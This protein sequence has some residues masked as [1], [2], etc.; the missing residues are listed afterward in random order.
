MTYLDDP[1]FPKVAVTINNAHNLVIDNPYL[2][3]LL[4]NA[5]GEIIGG[6]YAYPDPIPANGSLNYEVFVTNVTAD[7]PARVEAYV[8]LT[9]W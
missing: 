5:E 1:N 7:P 4:F 9:S 6:N 3:V 8:T 2:S